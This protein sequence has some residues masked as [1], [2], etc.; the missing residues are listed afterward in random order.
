LIDIWHYF[1]DAA[2]PDVADKLLRNIER[3]S[4]R[5]SDHPMSGRPRADISSGL[6]SVLVHPYVVV[7]RVTDTTVEIARVLHERRDVAAVFEEREP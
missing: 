1:A 4:A 5:L 3:A 7:Y 2:S 6:R